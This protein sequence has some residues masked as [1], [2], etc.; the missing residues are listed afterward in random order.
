LIT[1]LLELNEMFDKK[2]NTIKSEFNLGIMK[3]ISKYANTNSTDPSTEIINIGQKKYILKNNKVHNII[4]G[5][6][7]GLYD[8]TSNKCIK[9]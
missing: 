8:T 9:L 7:Y 6:L 1:E 5:S 4:T 3:I 2:I